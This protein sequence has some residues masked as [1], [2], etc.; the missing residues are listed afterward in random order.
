MNNEDTGSN[1]RAGRRLQE[2]QQQARLGTHA[3]TGIKTP[4]KEQGKHRKST[5]KNKPRS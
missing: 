3:S 2:L 1:W 4:Q 5:A